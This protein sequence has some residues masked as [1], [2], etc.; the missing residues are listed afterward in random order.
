ME[1]RTPSILGRLMRDVLRFCY[2]SS[3]RV[4]GQALEDT[5]TLCRD[6]W[7]RIELW[8]GNR[9]VRCGTPS[10]EPSDGCASCPEAFRESGALFRV[11]AAVHYTPEVRS[12]IHALKYDGRQSL[13][14]P[15]ADWMLS[16][17]PPPY[18][19]TD[20]VALVPVPLHRTRL[21]DRGFNQAERISRR[22]ADGTRL[23]VRPRW[24]LRVRPTRQL[25]LLDDPSMRRREVSDAFV[26][27]MPPEAVGSAVLLVDDLVTTGATAAEAAR[28]LRTA[29]AASVDV[30]AVA[31][32]VRLGDSLDT[33]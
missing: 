12:L 27:R 9:C 20:Y 15:L 28:A 30:I 33:V 2:P 29:G 18:R 32:S 3:C 31:R 21:A 7:Q 1:E 14:I 26:G 16:L 22:L 19:W 17:E 11:R 5:T 13:A 24:L 25:S 6:C 4:C 10:S 23:P 8:H